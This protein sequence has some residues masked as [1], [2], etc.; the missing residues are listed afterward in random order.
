MAGKPA[1]QQFIEDFIGG[2]F[3]VTV[4]TVTVT[5]TATKLCGN[6][7]E[8]MALTFIDTGGVNVSVLPANNV[9]TTLGVMLGASGGSLG[10]DAQEDLA[11]VGF[12]WWGIVGGSSTTVTVIE[13]IRFNA[14]PENLTAAATPALGG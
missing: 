11:V 14:S 2:S 3:Q 4:T 1:L 5:T 8:R 6:N 7:Y 12:D 9:S 13:I 10:L